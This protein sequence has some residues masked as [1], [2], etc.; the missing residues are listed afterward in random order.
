MSITT[1]TPF[2]TPGADLAVREAQRLFDRL[3]AEH[4]DT[5]LESDSYLGIYGAV[6]SYRTTH[7]L[8]LCAYVGGENILFSA[9]DYN[10]LASQ[11]REA[12][13]GLSVTREARITKL[14]AELAKLEGGAT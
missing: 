10:D 7:P 8:L 4:P 2:T 6:Q 9:K 13:A 5:K 3:Q 12:L 11:F 1:E 14:R